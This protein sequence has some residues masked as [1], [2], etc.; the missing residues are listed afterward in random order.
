MRTE[1]R[2]RRLELLIVVSLS[3][4]LA[5]IYTHGVFRHPSYWGISDWDQHL[6]WH[7][8]ARRTVLDFGQ[9]PLWNP[10]YCGG[11]VL[12]AN[13][14]THVFAPSFFSTLLLGTLVGVKLD[15][16]VKLAVGLIGTYL[17]G[18]RASLDRAAAAL[19]AVTFMLGGVYAQTT[20]VGMTEFTGIAFV[21]WVLLALLG[22]RTV[23][24]I[25]IGG[26][27]LALMI[28]T[29]GAYMISIS[30]LFLTIFATG[31][32][33]SRRS[34]APIRVLAAI[35]LIGA[36]LGAVKLVPEL[37]FLRDHPRRIEDYSGYSVQ[38]LLLSLADREQSLHFSSYE[39]TEGIWRGVSWG[40][41]E[42]L[43]YVGIVP[44]LL[45]LA[46]MAARSGLRIPLAA[47]SVI[48]FWLS[49]GDRAEPFSLWQWLH[50]LPVYESMRVAQRFRMPLLLCIALLGGLGLQLLSAALARRVGT[51]R[52]TVLSALIVCAV[53]ADLLWVNA[54]V[55]RGAFV[56]PPIDVAPARS[57][58]QDSY[59]PP[60]DGNGF[61]LA[62]PEGEYFGSASSHLPSALANTGIIRCY[63][64]NE[65][66]RRAIGSDS[67]R[68]RGEAFVAAAGGAARFERWT[69]NSW[70]ITAHADSDGYLVVNQSRDPGWRAQRAGGRPLPVVDGGRAEN[71]L[72]GLLA[73]PVGRGEST[74]E[75]SYRPDS[76]VWG[77][78]LTIATMTLP[79]AKRVRYRHRPR[80]LV[81]AA[82]LM[83]TAAALLY[84]VV[85]AVYGERAA[86]VNVRWAPGVD[87]LTRTTLETRYRL[88]HVPLRDGST[89]TYYLTDVSQENVRAIVHDQ[90]VE[91]T[92]GL[93]RTGYHI[94]R[95][96]ARGEYVG[97]EGSRTPGVL[98]RLALLAVGIAGWLLL[99]AAWPGSTGR[100][101]SDGST[102]PLSGV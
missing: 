89:W 62:R 101:P 28:L 36:G 87:D 21:P 61:M 90:R 34:L 23:T 5:A 71:G 85:R 50:Q 40:P 70:R 45:A 56:L 47:C 11:L 78:I 80:R 59:W 3:I 41:D 58:R 98:T 76:F 73:V 46:G 100:A 75:L 43:M 74:V 88:E 53:A 22:D 69:P 66:E 55:L 44:I 49:L 15:L 27:A 7:E 39:R 33:I 94:A 48:F 57:F 67:P 82:A 38:G 20:V 17:L 32:S 84:G 95:T 60:Y 68:Y 25:A 79:I 13:P 9:V 29:G 4:V 93:D 96:A 26:S 54:P 99:S 52:A 63:E 16:L 12:L 65:V 18:R 72:E 30:A 64:T 31:L 83:L 97:A 2:E 86:F 19:A 77:S 42:N 1:K 81:A 92:N 91:D 37:E 10:Y 6:F 14:L 51:R 35:A 24:N 8:V 102:K